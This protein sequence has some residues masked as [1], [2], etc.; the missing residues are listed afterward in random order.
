VLEHIRDAPAFMQKLLRTGR[1][2]I[3]SVPYKWPNTNQ[4]LEQ[5]LR[6]F[7]TGAQPKVSHHKHDNIDEQMLLRWAAGRQPDLSR[8]VQETKGGRYSRRIIQVYHNSEIEI[9]AVSGMNLPKRNP[10]S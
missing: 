8:I 6:R 3:V 1:T 10:C 2:V 7:I 5:R 4:L 9:A